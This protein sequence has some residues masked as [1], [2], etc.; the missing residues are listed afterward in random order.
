MKELNYHRKTHGKGALQGGLFGDIYTEKYDTVEKLTDLFTD[1]D[2]DVLE[3][4]RK[5]QPDAISDETTAGEWPQY[6]FT[7]PRDVPKGKISDLEGGKQLDLL[8][9]GKIIKT[10]RDVQNF[11]LSETDK[12]KEYYKL[13]PEM[14][15][16]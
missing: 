16:K 6:I 2:P 13:F 9:L 8:M 11:T 1:V 3:M 12:E 5:G 4:I 14:R 7:S 10:R 15:G